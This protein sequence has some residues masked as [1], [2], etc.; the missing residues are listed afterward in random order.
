MVMTQNFRW[1]LS[2]NNRNGQRVLVV[3]VKRKINVSPEWAAKLR[4]NILSHGTFPNAQYFLMVFPD[5][6]YLWS[7]A[8]ADLEP[9]E[10]TYT[11][12]ASPIFQPYFDRAGVTADQISEASL[13]LIIA[14]WLGEIIYSDQLPEKIDTTQHWLIESGLYAVS[15]GG[16]LE[17][18]A[19]A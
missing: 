11:I 5:K 7:N 15:V 9:R 6:F 1:D 8:E 3:E 14:S 17:R 13:E 2:V 12:D 4:R 16:R 18:E 19:V 10:P